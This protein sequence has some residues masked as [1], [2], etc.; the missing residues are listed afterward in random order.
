MGLCVYVYR[1]IIGL[2]CVN[3]CANDCANKISL[4]WVFVCMNTR[5]IIGLDCVNDCAND[6]AN[7]CD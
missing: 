7:K 4:T 2:D 1:N 5:N 3:D 6:C